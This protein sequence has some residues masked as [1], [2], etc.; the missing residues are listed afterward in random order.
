VA[1]GARH[2]QRQ[3]VVSRHIDDSDIGVGVGIGVD[4]AIE[5]EHAVQLREIARATH[6]RECV[7]R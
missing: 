1:I 7:R 2:D 4:I 3:A 6:G 5:E